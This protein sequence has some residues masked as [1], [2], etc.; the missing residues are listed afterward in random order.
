M[1]RKVGAGGE[2]GVKKIRVEGGGEGLGAGRSGDLGAGGQGIWVQ[3]G[4][5]AWHR[6]NII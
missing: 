5:G 6:G 1:K 4:Q 3:G 2:E